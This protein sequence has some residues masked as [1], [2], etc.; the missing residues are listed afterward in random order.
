MAGSVSRRDHMSLV[1]PTAQLND[2]AI[3][4]VGSAALNVM[5]WAWESTDW[6]LASIRRQYSPNGLGSP[7]GTNFVLVT[8]APRVGNPIADAEMS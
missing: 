2:F 4:C 5:L 3:Q 1:S 8:I 7:A 6:T